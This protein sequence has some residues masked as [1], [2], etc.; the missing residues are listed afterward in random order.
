MANPL[1]DDLDHV[2]AHTA[3]LWD[4]LRGARL[5]LTGGTGFFGCWLLETF[6]WANDHL[7]L[8][9]SVVVL[10]RDPDAFANKAPHL[11]SHRSVT[12]H[13]GDVRTFA[14]PQGAFSHVIH[15]ATTSGA[16]LNVVDRLPMFDTIVNGTR[17]A[18][19]F[20]RHS[21][22]T[23]FL[24][25]SSGAVYGRQPSDLTHLP[26]DYAGGPD[27]TDPGAV[28]AEG[29]R[30]AEMLCALYAD[31]GLQP[32]IARCFAFVGPYLPLDAHFAVGNF[33]RD[34]LQGGPIRVSGDGTPYRSY[35]YASDLAIW[36]W[37]ILLRGKAM[38]PYNVGSSEALTIEGLA[39]LVAQNL[40]AEMTIDVAHRPIAGQLPERYVPDVVRAERELAL[41]PLVSVA[42]GIRRTVAWHTSRREHS[43]TSF[44]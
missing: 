20:A 14:F 27:P 23:R 26:E 39:R 33:I 42:D 1:A 38:R 36:L 2:L 16:T 9:A 8:G 44:R 22:A 18:L 37:T 12:L 19:D 32:T 29:K 40:D 5:F 30:S 24:L 31:A 4:S 13:T 10:T 28:Y 3:G 25:T 34:R 17:R 21:G 43:V 15:A 7:G 6:L 35:L 11:A 41:R